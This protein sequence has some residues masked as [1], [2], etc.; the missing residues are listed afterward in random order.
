LPFFAQAPFKEREVPPDTHQ[1]P[2]VVVLLGEL[3]EKTISLQW[4]AFLI[5]PLL[6]TGFAIYL[7][8]RSRSPLGFELSDFVFGFDLGITATFTLLI[9]GFILVKSEPTAPAANKQHYIVG[10][11]ILLFFFIGFLRFCA[12]A[13]REYGLD[14]EKKPK[15][16]AA[17]LIDLG[18]MILLVVAF[19]LTGGS[20]R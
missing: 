12:F 8:S 16:I 4:V 2:G 14:A 10:L 7:K 5:V 11:F 9:S 3:L 19:L 15:K 6:I 18:G 13:M 17:L 20:F 1:L